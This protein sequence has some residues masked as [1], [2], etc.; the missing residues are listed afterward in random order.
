MAKRCVNG[1][2]YDGDKFAICPYCGAGDED[3]SSSIPPTVGVSSGSSND[4]YSSSSM[5]GEDME[6]VRLN[7]PDSGFG[8]YS[9]PAA[10]ECRA[11][12]FREFRYQRP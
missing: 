1:H 4:I 5:G 8:G 2:Y 6:T 9:A 11:S 12:W 7:Q 10:S 3:S